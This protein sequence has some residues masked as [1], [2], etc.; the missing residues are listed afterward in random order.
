MKTDLNRVEDI[1][2]TILEKEPETRED[3]LLLYYLFCTKYGF[4][5]DSSFAKMFKDKEYRK[6][7]GIA[8]FKSVERS[9][10]KIQA[11]HKELRPSEKV[12]KLRDEEESN[13]INYAIG[14]YEPT[15][16]KMVDSYE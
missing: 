8:S 1:V 5:S 7:L 6:T 4:L 11:E 12:Q 10:R 2:K 3:D 15:F 9:R 13:Y 16:M 14:G